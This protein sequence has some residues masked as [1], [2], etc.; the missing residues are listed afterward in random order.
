MR[1]LAAGA[2]VAC[3]AALP[4]CAQSL[5]ERLPT[6]FACHGKKG[7]SQV[8][9]NTFARRPTRLLHERR[10]QQRH[11]HTVGHR[12]RNHR[13]LGLGRRT[14]QGALALLG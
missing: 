1:S 4:L 12:P 11:L 10:P 5:D 9:E 3:L 13:D 8:P 14:G 7:T 2:I 6:C